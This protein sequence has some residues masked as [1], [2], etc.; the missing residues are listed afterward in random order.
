MERFFRTTL[1][2]PI[3]RYSSH[4][5]GDIEVWGQKQV[6]SLL[7]TNQK[8]SS[9]HFLTDGSEGEKRIFGEYLT[10]TELKKDFA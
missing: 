10:L 3:L 4:D 9:Q 5:F 6:S 2:R 7:H 8:D 1:G